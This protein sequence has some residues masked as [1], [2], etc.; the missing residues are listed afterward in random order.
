MHYIK[1]REEMG[2]VD[3]GDELCRI[4]QAPETPYFRCLA[5]VMQGYR[6]RITLGVRMSITWFPTFLRESMGF[7]R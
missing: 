2:F 6:E 5:T 3:R 1:P 4:Y 7:S